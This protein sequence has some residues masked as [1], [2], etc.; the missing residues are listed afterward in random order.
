MGGMQTVRQ[1]TTHFAFAFVLACSPTNQLPTLGCPIHPVL[2]D[3]WDHRRPPSHN[4]VLS[5]PTKSPRGNPPESEGQTRAKESRAE[6]PTALPKTGSPTSVFAH[7]G[8]MPERS[9]KGEVTESI[10]FAF[11]FIFLSRFPPKN[12]M[13][14]PKTT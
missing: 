4:T 5:S 3:G 14:S 12:R 9:P 1:P 8:V 6:S 7:W 11:V 13:S 2:C 10:A